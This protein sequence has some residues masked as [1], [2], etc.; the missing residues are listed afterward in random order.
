MNISNNLFIVIFA[1][2]TIIL[3]VNLVYYMIP[4]T[5]VSLDRG[6]RYLISGL[7]SPFLVFLV[8]FI[9]PNWRKPICDDFFLAYLFFSIVQIGF[10]EEFC[11]YSIFQWVSAERFSRKHDLPVATMYY[12][13]MTALGFALTENISYLIT[14]YQSK[15]LDPTV[16]Q[17]QL[18]NSMFSMAL[19][20]SMTA[21]VMHMICGIIIGYFI[22]LSYEKEKRD[23]LKITNE[24]NH[25]IKILDK[26]YLFYGIGLAAIFHGIYDLNLILPDNNYKMLFCILIIVFGLSIGYFMITDLIKKSKIQRAHKLNQNE[27]S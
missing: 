1:L 3:Y 21:V 6:R 7:M 24:N 18:N 4:K 25:N 20:R 8:Y 17:T 10:L 19:S 12:S 16:T 2:L 5:Y 27:S 13:F 9:L 23:K 11:K 22:N 15:A 14:L 26:I